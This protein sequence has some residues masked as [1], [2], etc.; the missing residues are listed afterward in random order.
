MG[1]I[2]AASGSNGA[3]IPIT[4]APSPFTIASMTWSRPIRRLFGM[5]CVGRWRLPRCQ[6]T[7]TR[8]CGSLPDLD[9][10]LG[11]GDHLDEPAVLQHQRI[12]AAQGDRVF[13]GRAGSRAA[14]PVIAIRRRCR[15][16]KSSTTVSAAASSSD[17]GRTLWARI[18]SELLDL[19][20]ADDL[21]H[22]G[23]IF[24]GADIPATP[25]CAAPAMGI[26]IF[27][28]CPALDHHETGW[29]YDAGWL[30]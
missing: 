7:R 23:E 8:C 30:S 14:V 9:Q 28:G 1:V 21:D 20:V 15:S 25:S 5:I 24:S 19:A 3:S 13:G 29:D 4:R 12:A 2:G 18:M 22:V 26:Q 16:S 27:A 11:G 17:A 10:R 6:A